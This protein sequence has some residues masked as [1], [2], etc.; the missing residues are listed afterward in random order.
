MSTSIQMNDFYMYQLAHGLGNEIQTK[1]VDVRI[2]YSI[3]P[4]FEKIVAI[5]L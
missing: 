2:L 3:S 1:I 5:T 4:D